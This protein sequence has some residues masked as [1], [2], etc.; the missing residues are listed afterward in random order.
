MIKGDFAP[1]GVFEMRAWE[2]AMRAFAQKIEDIRWIIES[3]REVSEQS[4]AHL[5]ED[6]SAPR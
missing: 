2:A 5:I 3:H 4:F 6:L 1:N